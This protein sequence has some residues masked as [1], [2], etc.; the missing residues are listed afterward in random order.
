MTILMRVLLGLTEGIEVIYKTFSFLALIFAVFV[1]L[2][3]LPYMEITGQ[4]DI[5]ALEM[6]FSFIVFIGIIEL[7]DRW[8]RFIM[9]VK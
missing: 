2:I 7:W 8:K 5:P 6:Y 9:N 1:L 3:L 4:S